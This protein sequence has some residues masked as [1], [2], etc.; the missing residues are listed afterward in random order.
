M[1]HLYIFCEVV[2]FAVFVGVFT[3][4]ANVFKDGLPMLRRRKATLYS[5]EQLTDD[6]LLA[7]AFFKLLHAQIMNAFEVVLHVLILTS[8]LAP[9]DLYQI[10]QFH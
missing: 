9:N 4:G 2:L 7:N 3:A 5:L 10:Q 8:I 1:V 6:E